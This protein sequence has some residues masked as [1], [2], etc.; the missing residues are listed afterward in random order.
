ML[1]IDH[2]DTGKMTYNDIDQR[3]LPDDLE[4]APNGQGVVYMVR[5]KGIDNLWLQ[6]LNGSARKQLTHFKRNRIFRFA[7]S[8]TAR[9]SP[10]KAATRSPTWSCSTT[11]PNNVGLL[12]LQKCCH[13]EQS[14]GS[15]LDMLGC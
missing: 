7:F 11:P 5:E 3:A 1:G 12:L 15:P 4:F 9:T 6:P 14:E 13:P 10:S 2:V 8:P